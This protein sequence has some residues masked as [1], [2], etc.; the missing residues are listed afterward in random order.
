VREAMLNEQRFER[1][2]TGFVSNKAL[3]QSYRDLK[4]TFKV[5]KKKD[6]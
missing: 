2:V 4:S 3:R 5:K 1:R 6:E